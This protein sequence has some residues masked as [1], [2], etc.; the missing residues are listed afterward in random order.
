MIRFE[1][2][3]WIEGKLDKETALELCQKAKSHQSRRIS[4]DQIFEVLEKVS[5]LW[6]KSGFREE[7]ERALPRLTGFSLEMIKLGLDE[8]S[9]MLKPE[10]LKTKLT[11]ELRDIPICF[12][13]KYDPFKRRLLQYQPLGTL[14]HV[15]SG[16]VFLV[17]PGSWIEGLITSNIN[18]LKLPTQETFFM[19]LFLK[20]IATVDPEGVLTKNVA[21]IQV[22]QSEAEVIEVFKKFADGIIVWGGEKAVHSYRQ[23]LPARTKMI[24]FGPKLSFSLVTKK[25]FEKWGSKGIVTRLSQELAIWDQNACTAPQTLYI[26]SKEVAM[27][28]LEALPHSLCEMEQ[29]IPAGDMSED[30]AV[31]IRKIRGVSEIDEALGVGALRDSGV[32]NLKWTVIY[33]DK[34]ELEPSPLHRTLRLMSF[35]NLEEIMKMLSPFRGYLQTVGL[36][37]GANEFVPLAHQLSSLG[38]QRILPLGEMS[39]G[40]IDDPHDGSYDLELLLNLVVIY[41]EACLEEAQKKSGWDF[42]T[43]HERRE[44]HDRALRNLI[45]ISKKS[46]FYQHRFSEKEIK[47]VGDLKSIPILTRDEWE[48]YM[49]P[50]T[51]QLQTRE[52]YGGYVTRSGGSSGVP[53]F[54]YFDKGDWSQ[55]IKSAERIFRAGGF[56]FSDRLANFMMA[57]D[58]YG[59]FI[60]FNHINYELGMKNFCFAG[61][62]NPKIFVDLVHSFNINALQGVPPTLMKMLREAK[63][64]DKNLKIEKFMY[65]GQPLSHTDREWL[66]NSLGVER[67]VSIIGTTE[68]NHIGYQCEYQSDA[69]HHLAEDYNYIEIVDDQGDEIKEGEIGKLIITSLHKHNYPVIRF[70]IGDVARLI[71]GVCPCGRLDRVIDYKGRWDDMVSVG[72]MNLKFSDLKLAFSDLPIT[73][74][75]IIISFKHHD[76]LIHF[77]IE[78]PEFNSKDL[79]NLIHSNLFEKVNDWKECYEK[80]YFKYNVEILPVGGIERNL[81]TG[82]VKQVIDLRNREKSS[83]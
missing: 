38:V 31:E 67:I 17:G 82:K 18:I 49:I 52:S 57:G 12:G 1:F 29:K 81:R 73:E 23:D 72:F 32:D 27:N 36:V 61:Q 83:D 2:G 4:E 13:Y 30:T 25:G 56:R 78:S 9:E 33:Q 59:S 44:F 15:L 50:R 24:V 37:A 3:E 62:M 11:T 26:E 35:D 63:N 64:L 19:P 43:T 53:K 40:S 5:F 68:A 51:D 21:L 28:L 77:K 58:L 47:S 69:I 65:A 48:K 7:A 22:E 20:S 16:N 79:L 71:S 76:E 6:K 75:Q 42:L 8:L 46:E 41:P 66:V 55:M 34:L 45:R 10:T 80:G 54:S 74:M 60:S 14:F 70:S 39:G